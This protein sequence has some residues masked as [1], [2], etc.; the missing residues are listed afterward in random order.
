MECRRRPCHI[1]GYPG[2]TQSQICHDNDDTK[3][4]LADCRLSYLEKRWGFQNKNRFWHNRP[5]NDIYK[6]SCQLIFSTSIVKC[7][8]AMFNVILVYFRFKIYFYQI[9]TQQVLYPTQITLEKNVN[10]SSSE[11]L[12]SKSNIWLVQC[13]WSLPFTGDTLCT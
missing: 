10:L 2:T 4:T 8:N 1:A 3:S 13:T 6:I 7:L 11:C 12:T 9:Q 5:N